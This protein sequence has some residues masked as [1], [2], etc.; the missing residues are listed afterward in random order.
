MYDETLRRGS[1]V[2]ERVASDQRQSTFGRPMQD[3]AVL[4]PNDFGRSNNVMIRTAWRRY[5]DIVV[6]QDESQRTK[7]RIAMGGDSRISAM[8][9]ECRLRNVPSAL[10]ER[11]PFGTFDDGHCQAEPRDLKDTK[12]IAAMNQFLVR[13]TCLPCTVFQGGAVRVHKFLRAHR[14]S[15]THDPDG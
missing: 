6:G 9:G 15:C 11:I 1:Q 13:V 7:T 3:A 10:I 8:A 12:N 2:E 4:W 5:E 14:Q